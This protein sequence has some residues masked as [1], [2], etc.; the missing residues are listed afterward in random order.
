MFS[1]K[2]Q[3][4]FQTIWD[5]FLTATGSNVDDT[6]LWYYGTALLTT[7]L[8]WVVGGIYLYMDLTGRPK[9]MRKYKVQ[10]GANE[11][12]QKN[13]VTAAIKVILINQTLVNGIVLVVFFKA[14]KLRGYQDT[15][16]LPP[17]HRVL[18]EVLFCVLTNEILF[19]Y[20]H[21]L[22][23]S[24]RLYRWIH[25]RHHEWT[26]PMAITAIYCHPLEH[27][28]SNLLPA[29]AGLLICGSHIVTAWTFLTLAILV[30]L[31]DHSGYHLPF[32]SS[33]EAHDFHHFK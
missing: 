5:Y 25:K 33:S 15:K 8:F 26:A 3:T 1:F 22:L 31:N 18:L 11:P 24:G 7:L 20:S 2:S 17:L 32:L 21:R 13:R 23:H 6:G 12:V 27:A 10:P 28:F 19:Y 9:F 16:V 4:L 14:L 29:F 30:I